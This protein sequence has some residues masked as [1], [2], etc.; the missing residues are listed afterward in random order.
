MP[1]TGKLTVRDR[2]SIQWFVDGQYQVK[3]WNT[4]DH[5]SDIFQ[6]N[7]N[8]G[9]VRSLGNVPRRIISNSLWIENLLGQVILTTYDLPF[10]KKHLLRNNNHFVLYQNFKGCA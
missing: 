2:L 6:W 8:I 1:R 3:R 4:I 5:P 9:S 7:A 10:P